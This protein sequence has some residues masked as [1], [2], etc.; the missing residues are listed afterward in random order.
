MMVEGIAKKI[1]GAPALNGGFDRMMVIVEHIQEK[2]EETT[3]KI[4]KI[5]EGLYEPD[6]GLYARV[7]AVEGSAVGFAEKQ[8]KHFTS[9]EKNLSDINASLKVLS[10]KDEELEGK[11]ETIIRLQKIA[12]EDLE[13]LESVIKVKN[14][15]FDASSKI[16]WLLAGGALAAIGKTVWETIFHR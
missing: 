8:I 1:N 6:E 2:Q 3:K 5:H 12:G 10:D 11:A 14:T 7:K 16:F 4:D 9:D 13:K 15:W